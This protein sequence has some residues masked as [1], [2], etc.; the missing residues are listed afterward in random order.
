MSPC[1][2]LLAA[3]CGAATL[4]I[5]ENLIKSALIRGPRGYV[6]VGAGRNYRR[7]AIVRIAWPVPRSVIMATLLTIW[8]EW[9][10]GE[11]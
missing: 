4:L 3:G 9:I 10:G 6:P 5:G 11:D 7:D 8:R 2:C 1:G